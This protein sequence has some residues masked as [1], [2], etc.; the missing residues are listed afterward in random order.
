MENE[1]PRSDFFRGSPWV[2]DC[3][4]S[5]RARGGR[6]PSLAGS[7]SGPGR[8]P[9]THGCFQYF[10]RRPLRDGGPPAR[11]LTCLAHCPQLCLVEKSQHLFAIPP[12]PLLVIGAPGPAVPPLPG[13]PAI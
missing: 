2:Q 1:C 8:G 5:A 11:P 10:A 12:V 4:G 6:A 9:L 7:R 13:P 3:N